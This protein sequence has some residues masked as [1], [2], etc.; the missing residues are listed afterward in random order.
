[1]KYFCC[2]CLSVS[3]FAKDLGVVAETFPVKE[4]SLIAF[5]Q[6]KAAEFDMGKYVEE[7]KEYV[8]N[9]TPIEGIDMAREARVFFF[10]PTHVVENDVILPDGKILARKGD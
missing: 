3:C 7:M 5:F 2:L 10:D 4:E 9:P 8:Q 6:K 1:M